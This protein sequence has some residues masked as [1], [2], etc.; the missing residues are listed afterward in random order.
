MQKPSEID[1][2]IFG[3]GIAGLWLLHR[4][5]TLG[6]DAILFE[7]DSLG[8]GQTLASQGIIHSGLKYGFDSVMQP[9][10]QTL[11]AMPKVWANCLTGMGEIDLQSVE[12]LA[13][14][15]L[16]F[17]TGGWKGRV[18]AMA[19]SSALRSSL[20]K[21]GQEEYPEF[22]RRRHFH[23]KVYRLNEPVL[24]TKSLLEALANNPARIRQAKVNDLRC[25]RH[26]VAEIHMGNGAG[27]R[28]RPRACIVT[29]GIGN[30]SFANRLGLSEQIRIQRRPLRMFMLRGLPWRLY[31]HCLVPEPRP[32]VTITTHPLEN[33]NIWYIGGNLAE[34]AVRIDK[35]AAL[36]MAQSEMQEIFPAVDFKDAR[37][38][39]YDV[40]RAEPFTNNL[41][42]TGPTLRTVQNIA[43]G[44][45]AKLA[46]A[47][48]FADQALLWLKRKGISPSNKLTI[49]PLPEAVVGNYPWEKV[50]EWIQI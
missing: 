37:W 18:A 38:A 4:L 2:A 17:T 41:L 26:S 10:M 7:R 44:W 34:K 19:A 25:L 1:V 29:S 33:E 36:K 11:A 50:H 27:T 15:Q 31:A 23:G 20:N 28:V 6:Y 32:R 12:V 24:A 47:P 43:F 21:L 42:P 40:E 16:A 9:Q 39:L 22:F 14:S 49:L 5:T 45:P 46:L 48:A 8:E 30:E 13:S 3:G 35:I